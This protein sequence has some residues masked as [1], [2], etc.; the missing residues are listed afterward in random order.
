[1][2]NS[3]KTAKKFTYDKRVISILK[4]NESLID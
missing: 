1:M 3:L 4:M 2:K